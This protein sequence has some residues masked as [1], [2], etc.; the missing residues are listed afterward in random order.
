[1]LSLAKLASTDQRYYLDQTDV[2]TATR[3]ASQAAPIGRN[4][5]RHGRSV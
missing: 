1:V 2:R 4:R 3:E 5:R